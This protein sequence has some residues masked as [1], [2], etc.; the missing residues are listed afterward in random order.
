MNKGMIMKPNSLWTKRFEPWKINT[1]FSLVVLFMLAACSPNLDT[2]NS[3]ETTAPQQMATSLPTTIQEPTATP[4]P[5]D[6]PE[7][8]LAPV[9]VEESIIL[10]MGVPD[11]FLEYYQ[12]LIEIFNETNPSITVE[13]KPHSS[14]ASYAANRDVI[15]DWGGYLSTLRSSFLDLTPY[16]DAETTFDR[17]DFYP[18]TL[19]LYTIDGEMR[20]IP[21]SVEP[22]AMYYNKD[23]FDRYGVAYPETGW[24][25]DDF[26][27]TAQALTH[28]EE[29]IWGYGPFQHGAESLNDG[30]IFV[31]QNGGQL[32]ENWDAAL[33]TF[34]DP[35]TV[36]A[37][38]WYVGL[39]TEQGVSPLPA[40]AKKLY[41]ASHNSGFEQG[42]VA[43]SING[44]L[45]LHLEPA[46]QAMNLGVVSV[47]R[48]SQSATV[49][50]A[51]LA[52]AISSQ[53][54][55]PDACWQLISFL[56]GQ[57][58]SDAQM[59]A[60]QSLAE[61]PAYNESVGAE[62]AEVTRSSAREGLLFIF[63]RAAIDRELSA[64][65][66]IFKAGVQ[67]VI[68]GEMTAQEAMDWAQ[69]KAAP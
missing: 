65:M 30:V 52:Y 38:E 35:A 66:D 36:A 15:L 33:P 29:G 64:Q 48:G 16:L 45:R 21:A 5:T 7:P 59:P 41:P 8:T 61:S 19:E 13:L 44:G 43:M 27:Q 54:E 24:T 42:Y 58:P 9:A 39:M 55:H 11:I 62:L 46:L 28:P 26:L 53:S 17:S 47:P 32:F 25:W 37:V 4:V 10:V 69:Q 50:S 23:I 14:E 2:P 3:K 49:D 20:L 22:F 67:K 60:R 56:E 57:M 40:E 68:A 18:P 12:G 34:N 6:E 51:I 31:Y 63:L 1:F